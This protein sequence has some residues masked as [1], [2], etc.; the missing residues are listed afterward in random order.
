MRAC[1]PVSQGALSSLTAILIGPYTCYTDERRVPCA[2]A[3]AN[4]HPAQGINPFSARRLDVSLSLTP[5]TPGL[6]FC[7]GFREMVR[8]KGERPER[9]GSALVRISRWCRWEASGGASSFTQI[10]HD[11]EL[12]PARSSAARAGLWG[13]CIRVPDY[14]SL[15]ACVSR[16]ASLKMDEGCSVTSRWRTNRIGR[17][18]SCSCDRLYLLGQL[19]CPGQGG[20][21]ARRFD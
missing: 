12:A 2:G 18:I 16:S 8:I 7:A 11:G 4:L 5:C 10:N 17:A 6:I 21:S 20:S 13:A 3:R 14:R 15:A 19:S 1:I 9:G